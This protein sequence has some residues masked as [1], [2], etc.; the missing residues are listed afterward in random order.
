MTTDQFRP[1]WPRRTHLWRAWS[2]VLNATKQVVIDYG[3]PAHTKFQLTLKSC[4]SP[5][6]F[7]HRM[8]Q[9]IYDTTI[10]QFNTIRHIRRASNNMWSKNVN[11]RSHRHF[12]ILAAA[13]GFVR[14]WPH[15]INLVD[16]HSTWIE[17][18]P[19]QHFHRF[20]HLCVDCSKFSMFLM[21]RT[22]IKIAHSLGPDLYLYLTDGS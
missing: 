22:T 10:L 20:G 19:K 14:P 21:G 9:Y 12:V 18:V 8:V 2:M 3:N 13:N 6:Q 5:Q 7:S 1:T 15:L 11:K 16:P 17:S 4:L